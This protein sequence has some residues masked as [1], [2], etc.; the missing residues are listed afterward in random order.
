M[1]AVS[2]KELI[3]NIKSLSDLK[4]GKNK[5]QDYIIDS[6]L[7]GQPIIS[8]NRWPPESWEYFWDF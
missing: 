2:G 5:C 7:E 6:I 3:L 4:Q 1:Q 8:E